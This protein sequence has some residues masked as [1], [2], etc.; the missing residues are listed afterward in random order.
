MRRKLFFCGVSQWA[1][2]MLIDTFGLPISLL[3]MT[4]LFISA[5]FSNSINNI[6]DDSTK[7]LIV[8]GA[9]VGLSAGFFRGF[10]FDKIQQSVNLKEEADFFTGYVEQ[11]HIGE[12]CH[13]LINL[14]NYN[15]YNAKVIVKEYDKNKKRHDAK[16]KHNAHIKTNFLPGDLVRF[17]GKLELPKDA[18]NPRCFD[19]RKYLRAK[20]IHFTMTASSMKKI[21]QE[22]GAVVKLKRKLHVTKLRF[23]NNIDSSEAVRGVIAGILFGSKELLDEE[24][25]D[26]FR[27]NSTAHILA[28]SG[29]HVG[30][31]YLLYRKIFRKFPNKGISAVFIII[32]LIYGQM[33]MWTPSVTRAIILTLLAIAGNFLNR[34]YDFVTAISATSFIMLIINPLQ[35]QL[36]SYQMSFLAVLGIGFLLP[37][38]EYIMPSWLAV[39]TS[40]QLPMS[41]Y[42]A[43]MFN[44]LSFGG[45]VFNLPTIALT[46]LIVPVGMAQYIIC[47]MGVEFHLLNKIIWGLGFLVSKINLKGDEIINLGRDVISPPPYIVVSFILLIFFFSSE[48]AYIHRKRALKK[49][50]LLATAAIFILALPFVK[51]D[52]T[53]FDKAGFVFVDVGQGDCLHVKSPQGKAM[54][55]DGGGSRDYNLGEKTL[56]PYLLKNRFGSLDLAAITHWDMDHSKGIEELSKCYEIRGFFDG[57]HELLLKNLEEEEFKITVLWPLDKRVA[58]VD[59]D[60]SNVFMVENKGIRVLVTGDISSAVED[61]LVN[62]YGNQ[63]KAHVLKVSHHGSRYSSS[64]RFLDT[65][66]PKAA[67]IGVGKNYYGHPADSVLKLLEERKIE[68]YRTDLDGAVGICGNEKEWKVVTNRSRRN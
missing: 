30:I 14:N 12:D 35:A 23:I 67:V 63:L 50:V 54:L 27:K 60:R 64:P 6:M 55:I 58:A 38:L 42:G 15:G 68:I 31:I 41:I 65:V 17:Q 10:E 46:A 29:L 59:N 9:V 37:I 52:I 57:K 61:T 4:F 36:P 43:Y 44:Y 11:S 3:T 47:F 19:Y 8:L 16:N 18:G 39:M 13:Y 26:A 24:L 7:K 49:E 62:L 56:K 2:I 20:E 5:K 33:T 22:Q 1:S 32:L 21:G 53:D 51:A 25:Y 34:A 28:V 48:W 66:K 45:F 40:V